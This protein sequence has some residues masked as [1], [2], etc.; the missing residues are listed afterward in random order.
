MYF[1]AFYVKV[2]GVN[3]LF[4]QAIVMSKNFLVIVH[5]PGQVR[6]NL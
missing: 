1:T 6:L 2:G 5:L 3:T 4:C